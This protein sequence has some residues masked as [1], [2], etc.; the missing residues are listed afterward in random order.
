MSD[1]WTHDVKKYAPE[2]DD[3]AIRGIVQHCGIA[4]QSKDASFVA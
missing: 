1:D 2:A 4:L 3:A